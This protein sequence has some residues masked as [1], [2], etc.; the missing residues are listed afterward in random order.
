MAVLSLI[1]SLHCPICWS[2]YIFS[3]ILSASLFFVFKSNLIPP[4]IFFPQAIKEK[5]SYLLG[6]FTFLIALFLHI[7]FVNAYDIKNQ[8]EMVSALLADWQSEPPIE[9]PSQHLIQ[10]GEDGSSI[11]IVEFADFLC[12]ACKR[13]Q[14]P[15]KKFLQNFPDVQF[16]FFAYPLDNTC[17]DSVPFGR[18]G[19]S[20]EL[21]KALV[22]AEDKAWE[23]HDFFFENQEQF[24]M[25]QNQLEKTQKLMDEIIN[26]TQLDKSRFENCMKE[27]ATLEKVK[28]SAQAGAQAKIEGT[29]SLFVNGKKLY[30]YDPQ[31]V[32]LFKIYQH[33]KSQ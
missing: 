4:L 19:L 5:N 21:S 1:H 24:S 6:G 3:F 7:S 30:S 18:S 22:C 33:L 11:V 2:L 15:L 29:P 20:C 23:F 32:L 12:P 17:N 8:T 28:L 25:A 10:K 26:A 16:Y 14:K 31:L 27:T 9:I 13:V